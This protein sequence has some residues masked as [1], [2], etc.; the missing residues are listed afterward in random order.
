MVGT[1]LVSLPV[2]PNPRRE[3]FFECLSQTAIEDV[4]LRVVSLKRT[5]R[6]CPAYF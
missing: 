4:A 5:A 2:L 1:P 3:L 6:T